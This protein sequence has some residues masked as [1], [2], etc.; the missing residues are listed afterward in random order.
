MIY[1]NT[2]NEEGN[3]VGY[4]VVTGENAA[5][6]Y[7]HI[8][9]IEL[10]NNE[11]IIL[12]TDGYENYFSLEKFLTVFK[13]WPDDLERQLKSL[14]NDIIKEKADIYGQERTLIAITV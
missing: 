6:N 1:R 9:T 3:L 13:K 2:V 10:K 12:Y 8:G 11:V 5:I 7:L 4:G 14:S